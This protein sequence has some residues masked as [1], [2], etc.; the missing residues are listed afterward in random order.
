MITELAEF[1]SG[2]WKAWAVFLSE[3]DVLDCPL[4]TSN[5]RRLTSCRLGLI[6]KHW[7]GQVPR[8]NTGSSFLHELEAILRARCSSQERMEEPRKLKWSRSCHI[9]QLR[10][11]LWQW[12][13]CRWGEVWCGSRD[14]YLGLVAL[15]QTWTPWEN[16]AG[17]GTYNLLG[18]FI[19]SHD[20]H[21]FFVG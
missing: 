18:I 14:H 12:A 15:G 10:S 8:G 17:W 2:T 11:T 21:L 19:V 20:N 16:V 3:K 5:R 4:Q 9:S 7:R 6:S 1:T 13:R